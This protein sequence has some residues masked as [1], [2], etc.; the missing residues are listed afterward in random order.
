MNLELFIAR[1]VHFSK[2]SAD[3]RVTPP[4]IRIA[5]AGIALGLATMLLAV[6]IVTGFKKEVRNKA[7]GFGAH[8]QIANFDSNSSYETNPILVN[9]SL[10]ADISDFPGV[11]HVSAY[12]TKPGILKTETD[13]QGIVL[14][15]VDGRYDWTFF[16]ENLVEGEIFALEPE[17]MAT[18]VLISAY[19]ANLLGLKCGDSFF[20]YFVQD[21]VRARKLHISGIYDTGYVDYD[22]FFV[23]ADLRQVRR[24]NGWDDEAV[25]GLE[26]T[27][28]DFTQLDNVTEQLYF[29]LVDRKDRMGNTYYVRSIEDLEP[30]L[31]NWLNVLDINAVIILVLMMA[32]AGFAM[33]SGLLIIIL[34][35][36]SMIGVL[37]ALGMANRPVRRVFLHIA[38][39]LITKGMLWG[40]V[41]G[42]TFCFLQSRFHL[43]ALDPSNYYLNAVP[44]D[45]SFTAWLL[46]NVGTLTVSMLMMLA[47]SC[48]ITK[49]SPARTIRF[50]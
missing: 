21:D 41:I 23:I 1:K 28:D 47:P 36:T 30:M 16:R 29:H 40:N 13:F 27:I 10:I 26:V 44:I 19:L 31:F 46:I 22:K 32:V 5:I 4:A 15:G 43:I 14:K 42:L 24:L 38:S 45:L 2:T 20:A 17:R 8:I 25:S 6:A 18:D 49:I 50:E 35:R 39:F 3:R 33:I 37:K 12:A 7:V 11:R 34:E 48:L 9:D